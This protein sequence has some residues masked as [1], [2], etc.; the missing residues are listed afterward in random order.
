[1]YSEWENVFCVANFVQNVEPIW[2]IILFTVVISVITFM[3]T[4]IT[5]ITVITV[6]TVVII[7]CASRYFWWQY[8]DKK[9]KRHLYKY[10][11]CGSKRLHK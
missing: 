2:L 7:L 5:G 3:F 8:V 11:H 1:M 6:P 4:V 9:Q 10:D